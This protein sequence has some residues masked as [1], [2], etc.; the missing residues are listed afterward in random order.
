MSSNFHCGSDPLI[1]DSQG[2]TNPLVDT[3]SDYSLVNHHTSLPTTMGKISRWLLIRRKMQG[4]LELHKSLVPFAGLATCFI[5][6]SSPFAR[7]MKSFPWNG[8]M[9][10][11]Y[12]HPQKENKK[13]IHRSRRLLYELNIRRSLTD[14]SFGYACICFNIAGSSS[15]H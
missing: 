3:W 14:S 1:K 10:T 6:T 11:N 2:L 4:F 13:A 7:I 15:Y 5:S 12:T 9:L 8:K